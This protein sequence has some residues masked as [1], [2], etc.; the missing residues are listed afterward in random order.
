MLLGI[1]M[2]IVAYFSGSLPNGVIIGKK[3]KNI[4]IREYGSKNTGATNAFRVLGPKLGLTVLALDILKGAL[5]VLITKLLGLGNNWELL[6]A[7]TAILG[8]TFSCFLSFKGGKGVATSLGV[9]IVLVPYVMLIIV[10]VFV[11]VVYFSKYISLGSII[12][13]ALFPILVF[14][15]ERETTIYFK[16]FSIIIGA[17]VIYKHKTNIQRLLKGEENKFKVRREKNE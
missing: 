4:D 2:I 13:S 12:A 5:P 15:L 11:L 17:Y 14:L 16:V 6:V 10:A 9:F 7:I 3:L 1:L 8:H